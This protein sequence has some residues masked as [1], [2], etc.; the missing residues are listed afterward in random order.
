MYIYCCAHLYRF[1]RSTGNALPQ[2]SPKDDAPLKISSSP[3]SS[4]AKLKNLFQGLNIDALTDL[5][6]IHSNQ[7]RIKR[8]SN[9]R[10]AL[11]QVTTQFIT[12]QAALN[13]RGTSFHLF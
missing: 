6:E 4:S 7:T 2:S 8:Q 1:T 3:P 12:P 13:N 10:E 5:T 11:C 9:G